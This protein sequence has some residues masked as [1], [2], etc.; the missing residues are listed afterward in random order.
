MTTNQ[1]NNSNAPG[2]MRLMT[3]SPTYTAQSTT[4]SKYW[5]MRLYAHTD[6][7]WSWTTLTWRDLVFGG[8]TRPSESEH[9]FFRE[10]NLGKSNYR[11]HEAQAIAEYQARCKKMLDYG[12]VG[13]NGEV[14]DMTRHGFEPCMLC[15]RYD[16]LQNMR[17]TPDYVYIQPKYD[18]VRARSDGE[19]FWSRGGKPLPEDALAHIQIDFAGLPEGC[20]LDGELMLPLP[21]TF[22]ES[23]SR[24]KKSYD[25]P[26]QK[27]LT[28]YVYDCSIKDGK[29]GRYGE[30]DPNG[31]C[32]RWQ[33]LRTLEKEGVFKQGVCLARC[34]AAEDENDVERIHRQY[35]NDGYEGSII[36]HPYAYYEPGKRSYY[37]LKNKD[38]YREAHNLEED[39]MIVGV[40][41]GK[42]KEAGHAIFQCITHEGKRFE[43]RP[44][45]TYEQR[46]IWFRD[47]AN[48]LAKELLLV[49][50][51]QNYTDDGIP[52]FPIGIRL[53]DPI[54]L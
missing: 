46:A 32:N 3:E 10:T 31:F 53:K 39:F 14:G 11:G 2:Y 37:V 43:T 1:P 47:R 48:I 16:S 21:H 35:V 36:R 52:R 28:Y 50:R 38:M 13:P 22:Q 27:Q 34:H 49:V 54:E 30:F 12:Y 45:G 29:T 33:T 20:V 44:Q 42:G 15:H 18:G 5:R 6:G 9:K 17:D 7:R 41:D 26:L 23:V 8:I 51:F 40:R 4:G 24:V 19:R 25:D